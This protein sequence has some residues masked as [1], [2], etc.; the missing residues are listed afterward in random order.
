MTLQTTKAVMKT[1]SPMWV[2][3]IVA[4]ISLNWLYICDR[5]PPPAAQDAAE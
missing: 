2:S 1:G 4:A 3:M 5:A